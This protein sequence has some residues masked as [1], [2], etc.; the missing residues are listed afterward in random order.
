MASCGNMYETP[1]KSWSCAWACFVYNKWLACKGP[2]LSIALWRCSNAT[3][4]QYA[5]DYQ[6]AYNLT[7]GF[8]IP[9]GLTCG[10][11]YNTSPHGGA[12][13][14][15]WEAS[16]FL[17]LH[18]FSMH[19]ETCR[20]LCMQREAERL[21]PAKSGAVFQPENASAPNVTENALNCCQRCTFSSGCNVWTWCNSSGGCGGSVPAGTCSL[22][23]TSQ[24]TPYVAQAGGSYVSGFFLRP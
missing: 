2:L 23:F 10:H 1:L 18:P 21:H 12:E 15:A 5:F 6:T 13:G 4:N 17:T 8:S 14:P 22:G 7:G 16:M 19:R 24:T 11:P 9:M 3:T 20:M